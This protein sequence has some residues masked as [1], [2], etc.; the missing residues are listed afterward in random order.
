M[1]WRQETAE[2]VLEGDEV[3]DAGAEFEEVAEGLDLVDE[4]VDAADL[5]RGAELAVGEHGG[6]GEALVVV[7]EGRLAQGHD[8]HGLPLRGARVGRVEELRVERGLEGPEEAV[9][10][11]DGGEAVE[12]EDD[13]VG[14]VGERRGPLFEPLLEA[15]G[16]GHDGVDLGG[17]MC[18]EARDSLAEAFICFMFGRVYG[19]HLF[20]DGRAGVC[21]AETSKH[22][23]FMYRTHMTTDNV[24][25]KRGV[26][27]LYSTRS[28]S[29]PS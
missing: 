7:G 3:E 29:S 25:K 9:S 21:A 10:L 22:I 19:S 15:R 17:G 16:G 28:V 8:D 6:L 5:L 11:H 1:R 23:K 12:G 18:A 24:S 4:S 26:G 20:G 13:G 2:G 27:A 14:R